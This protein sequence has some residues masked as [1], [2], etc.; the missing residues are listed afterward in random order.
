MGEDLLLERVAAAT[1]WRH[2][3]SNEPQIVKEDPLDFGFCF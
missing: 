3:L 1:E 2:F